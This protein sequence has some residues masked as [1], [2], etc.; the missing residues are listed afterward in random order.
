MTTGHQNATVRK[1]FSFD[2]DYLLVALLFII[3][4]FGAKSFAL[5]ISAPDSVVVSDNSSFFVDITNDSEKAIDLQVNFF[6]PLKSEVIAPFTLAPNQTTKAK[7][8]LHNTSFGDNTKLTAIVEARSGSTVAQKEIL[9]NFQNTGLAAVS[10]LFSLGA[11][12]G[13]VSTFSLA[14]WGIFWVLVIIAAVLVVAFVSRIK[15]R[16]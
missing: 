15:R 13:E 16:V 12:T 7:I 14:E 5:N 10:G 11:F 9:L 4:L 3:F 6:S 2:V 8:T 1:M